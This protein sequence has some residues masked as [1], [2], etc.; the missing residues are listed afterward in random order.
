MKNKGSFQGTYDQFS[1]NYAERFISNL[2]S[3]MHGILQLLAEPHSE[4]YLGHTLT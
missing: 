2:F 1:R 4:V 3:S